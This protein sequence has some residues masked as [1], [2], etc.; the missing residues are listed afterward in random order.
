MIHPSAKMGFAARAAS[1]AQGRPDYPAGLGA[2]LLQ[3]L[4]LTSGRRVLDLGA[5]TGKFIPLL[6]ATGAEI[7]AVEPVGPMRE[8]LAAAHPDVEAIEGTGEAIPL[9][10]RSVD[11]V[12]CAQSFHWFA[13]EQALAEIH[14]VLRPSGVL[15]LVWNERDESVPWVAA[16]DALIRPY[17]GDAPSQQSRE[18]RRLFPGSGFGPPKQCHFTH[19]HEGPPEIVIIER[20][21]S[22]SYIAA[23]PA[24]EQA[25][26]SARIA[27]LISETP[28]LAGRAR[29]AFPYQ[30][31][32]FSCIRVTQG[33]R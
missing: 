26:L 1:Y 9:P 16:L 17:R 14:R 12:T 19:V 10:D 29:V 32:A 21:L 8:R 28:A 20:C 15:G 18:W 23:L 22:I 33:D 25:A 4:G 24:E 31:T 5:G 30:T 3:D 6:K 27:A 13:N 2:W 7:I 11:A